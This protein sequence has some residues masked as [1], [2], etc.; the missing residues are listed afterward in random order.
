MWPQ[1]PWCDPHL[2][3]RSVI[4]RERSSGI[5]Q[6]WLHATFTHINPCCSQEQQGWNDTHLGWRTPLYRPCHAE[7]PATFHSLSLPSLQPAEVMA[8]TNSFLFAQRIRSKCMTLAFFVSCHLAP[9]QSLIPSH[10]HQ[11]RRVI[12][13]KYCHQALLKGP[14]IE[15]GGQGPYHTSL[16]WQRKC[17]QENKE[18]V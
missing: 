11:S 1:R 16:T 14:G 15:G 10:M 6:G 7:H 12:F 2:Y 4:H 17:G 5:I 3:K 9:I 8:L 18:Y 13:H